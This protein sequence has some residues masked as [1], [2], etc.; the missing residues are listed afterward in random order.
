[1]RP[2]LIPDAEPFF[3]LG[4]T[5]ACLLVHGFTASPREMRG[6]G[7]F[8]HR[9]HGYTVLGVRL[10]GHATTP[11]DMAHMR[12]QDWV[13]SAEDGWHMLQSAGF[14]DVVVVGLSM[15]GVVA[16]L[17]ASYLPV[18]GV[19]SMAAPYDIAIPWRE[20]VLAL[21]RPF[22]PK[23]EGRVFDPKGFE[24]RV[25]YPV[26]PA[27]SVLELEAMLGVLRQALPRVQAPALVLHSRDDLYVPPHNAEQIFAALR[28]PQKQLVWV[29]G[30]SHVVTLDAA[31][32]TVFRTV[33]D[34]VHSLNANA[35]AQTE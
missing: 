25:A 28:S 22:I 16:L 30:S 10:A 9:E 4:N 6:L 13:A 12:W 20:R 11:E 31:R 5:T 21:F 2:L 8:L 19:V 26:N 14:Q 29:E 7:A 24:G 1:M 23:G 18:K 32:E 33:G 27:R 34:F 15:G 17:L 3:Y 35:G